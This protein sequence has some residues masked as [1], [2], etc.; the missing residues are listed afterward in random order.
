M[1]AATPPR[2]PTVRDGIRDVIP[3]GSRL[4]REP[5]TIRTPRG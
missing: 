5:V 4:V 2:P 3:G 1:S